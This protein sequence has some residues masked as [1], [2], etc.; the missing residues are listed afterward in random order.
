VLSLSGIQDKFPAR[1][2]E[3][4]A[5]Q[6]LIEGFSSE[7]FKGA[8]HSLTIL[9]NRRFAGRAEIRSIFE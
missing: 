5:Q 8:S 3:L 1:N 4:I 2:S 9:G 7:L 6:E